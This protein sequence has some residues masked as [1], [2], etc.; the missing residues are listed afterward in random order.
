[1]K[2]R[3]LIRLLA[4]IL[5]AG[6]IPAM[7]NSIPIQLG[8]L[9]PLGS[10]VPTTGVTCIG[11]T[12]VTANVAGLG[13]I[14]MTGFSIWPG[15]PGNISVTL[16]GNSSN[17][18][19]YLGVAGSNN[20]DEVDVATIGELLQISFSRA[21]QV[22]TLDLNKLFVAGVRGDTYNEIA[23]VNFLYQGSFLGTSF[24]SGTQNGM[25]T[26]NSPFGN[27]KVDTI[28]FWAVP[29]SNATDASNSD[30]GVSGLVVSPVPE[31]GTLLLLGSGLAAIA[32]R[33]RLRRISL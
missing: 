15:T 30:Y 27:V 33:R 16:D 6:V 7:A 29:T 21:V 26:A 31:P 12:S 24:F 28:Q 18:V 9:V 4:L 8:T 2:S 14:T 32:T 22:T 3:L 20:D 1:M 17:S 10:C 19:P 5:F 23:G 25:L 11:P 13:T